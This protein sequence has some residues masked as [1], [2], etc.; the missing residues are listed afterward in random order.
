MAQGRRRPGRSIP[1]GHA[2]GRF[3][4]DLQPLAP[5]HPGGK[6]RGVAIEPSERIRGSTSR[7]HRARLTEHLDLG[8]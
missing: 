1:L 4:L 7:Q 8:L 6:D 3:P 2:T 5:Q